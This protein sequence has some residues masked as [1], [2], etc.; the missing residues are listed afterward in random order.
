MLIPQ[1]ARETVIKDIFGTQQRTVYTKGLLDATDTFD[2]DQTLSLLESK[3]NEMEMSVYPHHSPYFYD[4]LVRNK[5][6]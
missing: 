5:V 2:F 1:S 3:W 4:W 6:E